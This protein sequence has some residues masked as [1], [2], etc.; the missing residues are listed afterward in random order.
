MYIKAI[1][2]QRKMTEKEMKPK[3]AL[4][5]IDKYG[6]KLECQ[7]D[8]I[9]I[10]YEDFANAHL[11]IQKLVAKAESMKP[12]IR[13]GNQGLLF[14]ECPRCHAHLAQLHY[15]CPKENCGQAI[16]WSDEK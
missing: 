16:D 10:S 1:D 6:L 5:V 3:E 7:S 2:H 4:A 15:F 11:I 14:Y 12:I 8:D 13:G 9:D